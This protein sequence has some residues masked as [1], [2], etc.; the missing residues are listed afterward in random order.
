[1]GK[2]LNWNKTIRL[3]LDFYVTNE[4]YFRTCGAKDYGYFETKIIPYNKE[5]RIREIY[6]NSVREMKERIIECL[7]RSVKGEIRHL[8]K[9]GP[10]GPCYAA[11]HSTERRGWTPKK[12]YVIIDN[13]IKQY[14]NVKS[15]WP[16]D[17]I[18]RAFELKYWCRHYGGKRWAQGTELL[19]KLKQS[20][21]I[22]DDFY[23]IDRI[24]D[25]QHNTGFILNKTYFKY[26]S[27]Y[28]F[29]TEEKRLLETKYRIPLNFRFA[30]S[31]DQMARYT[32]FKV[33][34]IYAANKNYLN[35]AY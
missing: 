1:M 35:P 18:K 10:S 9:F 32:S 5:K 24:L 6:E 7:E 19:I 20:N 8:G 21:N 26:L 11:V 23:L 3:F 17:I 33:Y 28:E 2:P 16:L 13:W 31:I 27:N 29:S 12:N 22:K 15:L 25:L 34:K 30:A 14:G 4:L